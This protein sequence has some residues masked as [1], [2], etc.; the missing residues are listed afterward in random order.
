MPFSA[1]AQGLCSQ[2]GLSCRASSDP[3]AADQVNWDKDFAI[4]SVVDASVHE[5][6][7]Y[8]LVFDFAAHADVLGLAAKHQVSASGGW[9]SDMHT[10]SCRL[11]LAE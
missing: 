7:D 11:S 3:D 6:K 9:H 8:G 5:Q 4:G 1:H 10:L 2:A